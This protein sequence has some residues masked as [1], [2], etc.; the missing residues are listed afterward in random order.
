M[1]DK[2]HHS[3][4]KVHKDEVQLKNVVA[5]CTDLLHTTSQKTF[6][7]VVEKKNCTG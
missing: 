5:M 6:T 1:G 7:V 3:H 2:C 4:S